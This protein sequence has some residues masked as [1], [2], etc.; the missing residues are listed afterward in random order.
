MT[1]VV[2]SA[3]LERLER[4]EHFAS[5]RVDHVTVGESVVLVEL[6]DR[7]DYESRLAG[8]AHRPPG[9]V[10]PPVSRDVGTVLEPLRRNNQSEP[11]ESVDALGERAIAIATVNALS[12][13]HVEWRPGDPME[14]LSSAVTT[15]V[16]IGLFRP[17][18][19]KFDD[20]E[21]RVIERERLTIDS[22]ET[23]ETTAIRQFR[24]N[25]AEAATQNADVVFVTGSTFIYGGLET[26]LEATPSSAT[27]VVV[28]ASASVYPEPLFDRGVDIL[29]GSNITNIDRVRS[30]VETGGCG[31]DLHDRGVQKVISARDAAPNIELPNHDTT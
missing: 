24:P 15:V 10:S 29:A 26:Y 4:V 11:I 20:V 7:R 18:L 1:G 27:T 17:A 31:T 30:A 16:M 23:P 19:R 2:L 8:L 12:S 6:V 14:L 13:R 25:E 22:I 9:T 21:V 3:I 28:G 5:L